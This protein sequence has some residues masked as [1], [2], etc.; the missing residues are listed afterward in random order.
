MAGPITLAVPK[1]RLLPEVAEL[2]EKAGFPGAGEL[3][4]EEDRRL[5]IDA[6]GGELRYL[7]ARPS[8]VVT[9]VREGAADLGLTGKDTLLESEG[10]VYELLDLHIGFCRLV[11]AG[12]QPAK[13]KW[14]EALR[15]PQGHLRVATKY[16]AAARAYLAGRGIEARIIP[17]AGAV[18]VAPL[19]GMADIIVDLVATGRTLRENGLTEF[20][21]IT[22]ITVRLIANTSSLRLKGTALRP[23]LAGLERSV[24][25]AEP[26]ARRRLP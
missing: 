19:V 12:P 16:P 22:P 5:I 21:E 2:L 13:R 7:L 25:D 6:P 15:R 3:R 17:L 1:G 26:L 20:A 4:S 9:Y 18:E 11:V 14:Q 23:L 10:G 8:D 24:Q